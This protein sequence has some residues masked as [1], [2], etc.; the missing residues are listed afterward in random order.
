VIG[1]LREV[2]STLST[3]MPAGATLFVTEGE[4]I[5]DASKAVLSSTL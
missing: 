1:P 4:A 3:K 2:V 5:A